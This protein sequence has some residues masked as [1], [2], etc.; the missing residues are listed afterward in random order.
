MS[1]SVDRRHFLRTVGIAG[2]AFAL[3]GLSCVTGGPDFSPAEKRRRQGRPNILFL[4]S[5]DHA[6]QAIGAYGS[7]INSTPNID[8][9]AREGVILRSNTCCNSICAPSRASVLT[10]K[11]SHVNGLMTNGDRFDGSQVTFPKLLQGAGYQTAMVG[12]W[13]LKTDPTG[14]DYWDI[15]PGQGHYYNP[16]FI[17]ASGKRRIEGY[18]TDIVADLSLDW[19]KEGRDGEKPF[20]LM[21][22]FKAPHR[23]WMPGPDH[24]NLFDDVQLPV[25]ENFFDDYAGRSSSI[26]KNEMTIARH[27][28]PAYDLKILPDSLDEIHYK[29]PFARMTPEQFAR[30]RAAYDAKNEAFRAAGLEGE[31]LALWKY[32]RYVKDY[33][34]CIASVD[35]NVGRIL[36]YLDEA[37]L[38]DNTIVVYSS[39]Q[40]FYLGEHGFY[41]KRWMYRESLGMPFVAR[42]PGVIPARSEAREIT[43]NIDFA[44]TLLEAAGVAAP[45]AMQG[46]SFLGLMTGEGTGGWR[47]SI[48]YA[49]YEGGD[50]GPHGVSPHEGVMTERYKL[51]SFFPAGEW[52]LFDLEKDPAEM[53]S[54]YDD[55]DYAGVVIK[56]KAELLR[57]KKLYAVPER[58]E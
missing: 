8:R 45:A 29:G 18:N 11:H 40:G 23:N 38:A 56:L 28:K 5:D 12:K 52:E 51:I 6:C 4:F 46:E 9:I 30:F 19:L 54:V 50:R 25:P 36:D 44:P 37:G 53:K 13:H 58:G 22:Q 14:F 20:L 15:L 21:C 42:W 10:G 32:Q 27:M 55:P 48:Y 34:R 17:S 41:D 43:Q 26:A 3:P 31:E 39:D 24:L 2:T 35:D 47:S 16:D 49:Y 1:K 57:L 7:K 33:L